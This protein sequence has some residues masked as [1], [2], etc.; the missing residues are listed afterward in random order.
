MNRKDKSRGETSR[1]VSND[2]SRSLHSSPH[3]LRRVD[4]EEEWS[5]TDETPVLPIPKLQG[6]GRQAKGY[7]GT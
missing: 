3:L 6:S 2:E 4:S 7:P 5:A 1:D